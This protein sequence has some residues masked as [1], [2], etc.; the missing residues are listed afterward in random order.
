MKNVTR[1]FSYEVE[2]EEQDSSSFSNRARDGAMKILRENRNTKVNLVLK[3]DMSRMSIVTGEEITRTVPFACKYVIVLEATDLGELYDTSKREI[4]ENIAKYS[5]NGSSWRVSSILKMDINVINYDPLRASSWIEP[6]KF[7]VAKKAIINMKN[8]DNEC[9]K[10]CVTRAL[11]MKKKNNERID[12][13]LIEK[14]KE[15]HWE[16][17]EFPV[18]LDQIE[19]FEKNNADIS[20]SVFG[21]ENK[22]FHPLK[23]LKYFD[24]KYHID[25]LLISNETTSHYCLINNFSRLMTSS[26]SKNEHKK[27]FCRNCLQGYY[28]KEA[29]AKH[30]TYCK[31]HSCVR[32]ELPKEGSSVRFNHVER[33]MRVPFVVYADFES[34]I[35]PINTCSPNEKQSFTKQYQKHIPSSYCYNIKCFDETVYKGKLVTYTAMSETDDVAGKFVESIEK[36]IIDICESNRFPKKIA[37]SDEDKKKYNDAKD[38]LI[39]K[40]NLGNDKVRDHCLLSGK[41]RGAA[42]KDC[43]LK[44]QIPKFI[45]IVFHNLS[46]YDSHL[47]IKK[48]ANTNLGDQ[49]SISSGKLNCIPNNEEKYISFSKEIKVG[50]FIGKDGKTHEVK[51]ELRFIDSFRFMGRSLKDLTDDLVKDL[52]NECSRLDAKTCKTDCQERKGNKCKCKASCKECANRRSKKGDEMCKNLNLIYSGEKRDLLLRK[53]VYPC[54]WV[55]SIDKFSETQLPPQESFYSKLC[56]EGIS[57]ED[58]LHAQE[59]WKVFNCRTFRDYHNIYN[60]SDVLILADVFENFRNVCN[61]NYGLDPAHYYTSPGLACV[62]FFSF[63]TNQ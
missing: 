30:W 38:C 41:Y 14:S 6:D 3:C 58:Y 54:D 32:V 53:G 23:K 10:W 15:F 47:F 13:E 21:F 52:C 1:Q 49:R 42:H 39:C 29:R 16:G 59:M 62:V 61:E 60:V 26:T 55:D 33:S 45:P 12:K 5:S 36:D 43:N 18:K 2:G 11:N 19:K 20:V 56:D 44:C 27:Y 57:D 22:K 7:I 50:E 37:M 25:L 40:E 63:S 46:G 34:R 4:L 48:L 24:R 17:I 51:R 28:S 31:E 35:I 8:N 9:F